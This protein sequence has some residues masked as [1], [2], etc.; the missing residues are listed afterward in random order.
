VQTIMFVLFCY[1]TV[2]LK[3]LAFYSATFH[4]RDVGNKLNKNETDGK[5][6]KNPINNNHSDNCRTD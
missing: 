6:E 4:I 1:L 5:T 3:V 2:R